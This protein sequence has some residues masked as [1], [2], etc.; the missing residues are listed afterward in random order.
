MIA[1]RLL[2]VI[3][4][5]RRGYPAIAITGPRQSGKTTLALEACGK[6]LPYVNFESPL[7]RAEFEADPNG[8]LDQRVPQGAIL[9]EI[10][11]V[12]NLLSHLQV[13]I[14]RDRKMGQWILT[15]SQQIDV[16][17]N[18]SNSLAGR[19]GMLE[20]LPLS[21][22]ELGV[23]GQ[24]P[25]TL[26]SAV[27]RGGYPALYDVNRQL[28]VS[29][30][31]EDYLSTFI[32]RDIRELIEVRNRSAFDR[33]VRL[34]ASR[35]GQILNAAALAR[36]AGVDAKTA[37]AWLSAFEDCYLIRMVKPYARNFGKRLVKSPKLYFLDSGLACRLLHITDVNQLTVHP[38]FGHL[39]ETWCVD[40]IIKARLNR[41]LTPAI[42]YWRS[43]DGIEVDVILELGTKLY[44]FEVKAAK[45]IQLGD[46][47]A[48]N[49]FREVAG[50]DATVEVQ[51]AVV[52]YGGDEQRVAG[53][54]HFV[55]WKS[56]DERVPL[57]P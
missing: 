15:G 47:A 37:G 40:E 32:N 49:R 20:L 52:V 28:D 48:I 27:F 13:R 16:K 42:W 44:P 5:L 34:C 24:Q 19:V 10:Q 23:A 43:S 9:D 57:E 14:D 26:A 6:E 2:P 21:Y 30:W 31:L 22:D 45:T 38:L 53:T 35:T 55:S 7:E 25:T 54:D 29:R 56:I 36:D 46:R 33:F 11:H 39:V 1:R 41:G 18:V 50:T 4:E 12:P 17:V 3:H 51:P 8:F